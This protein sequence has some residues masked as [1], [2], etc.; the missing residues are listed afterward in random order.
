[1]WKAVSRE[2]TYMAMFP[3]LW[4]FPPMRC[5]VSRGFSFRRTGNGT[6][7]VWEFRARHVTHQIAA[8][9]YYSQMEQDAVNQSSRHSYSLPT[10][11]LWLCVWPVFHTVTQSH[12]FSQEHLQSGLSASEKIMLIKASSSSV[13]VIVR[14]WEGWHAAWCSCAVCYSLTFSSN[15]TDS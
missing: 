5:G 15:C 2:W 1:M 12:S 14:Q 4:S 8:L 3:P 7:L 11:T 10:G 9:R 6:N 13:T